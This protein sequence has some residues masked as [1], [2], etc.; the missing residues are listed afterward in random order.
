MHNLLILSPV[1]LSHIYLLAIDRSI[2]RCNSRETLHQWRKYCLFVCFDYRDF[3]GQ[4]PDA[5]VLT[6]RNQFGVSAD[7]VK[8]TAF[9]RAFEIQQFP[10]M[11]EVIAQAANYNQDIGVPFIRE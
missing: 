3:S 7:A 9:Q 10:R 8:R 5:V 6:N 2:S 4:G 11:A 1:T